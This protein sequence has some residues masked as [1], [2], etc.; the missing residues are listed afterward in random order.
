MNT[1]L[2]G[3]AHRRHI[4]DNARSRGALKE[5]LPRFSFHFKLT[6]GASWMAR[7]G[8]CGMIGWAILVPALLG[9][10][11]G[12]WLDAMYPNGFSWAS[13]LLPTGLFLGCLAAAYW[14]RQ[15]FTA[16]KD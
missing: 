11:V 8:L 12:L 4:P 9:L 7:L 14:F 3:K 5:T 13:F 10:S 6:R 1:L 16:P 2:S 15:D